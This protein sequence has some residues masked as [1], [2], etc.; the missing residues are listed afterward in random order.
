[1]TAV[2]VVASQI[3]LPIFPVPITLQSLAV[4]IIGYLLTPRNAMMSTLLF[5]I[6]GLIGLPVFTGFSGGVQSVLTP[7]FGFVISFIP[8][9]YF[10]AKYLQNKKIPHLKDFAIAGLI[11]L[12]F[13]YVIGLIYMTGILNIHL[14]SNLHL[15]G[16]LMVGLMPFIPGDILK[17]VVSIT[18]SK[19]LRKIFLNSKLSKV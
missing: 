18:L 5:L 3:A 14:G 17:F 1:M 2:L 16:V 10:Q 7:S 19:R 13:M 15:W 8:A 6:L 12:V 9:S 4:L 11:N